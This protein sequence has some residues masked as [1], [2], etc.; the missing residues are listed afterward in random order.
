MWWRFMLFVRQVWFF[1]YWVA[2]L[3]GIVILVFLMQ[4]S[5]IEKSGL[6]TLIG[7]IISIAFFT[8]K[9]KLE[10]LREFRVLF[11][12]FNKQYHK[13][14][15]DLDKLCN[16][17][18]NSKFTDEQRAVVIRYFNLCAEEFLFY[19]KGLIY[20]EVWRAWRNGM[21]Q[22]KNVHIIADVWALE[23]ETSSYYDF[24]FPVVTHKGN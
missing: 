8:Q 24:K 6:V 3:G 16:L 2:C 7:I 14:E 17:D 15:P 9:Q 18:E 21:D 5:S 19:K 4:T 10:E 12:G 23:Y 13:L 22:Y 20:R 1:S 11:S